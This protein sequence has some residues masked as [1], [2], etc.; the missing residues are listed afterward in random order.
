MSTIE[1]TNLKFVE[2][3][4][5]EKYQKRLDELNEF[6]NK[7]L[8]KQI[9]EIVAEDIYCGIF[10]LTIG[11][12]IPVIDVEKPYIVSLFKREGK[13]KDNASFGSTIKE[14]V[15]EQELLAV[16]SSLLKMKFNQYEK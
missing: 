9:N 1:N 14:C 11:I 8:K 3:R 10:E 4:A 6:L 7:D 12:R 16:I 13:N 15:G 5:K 2:K